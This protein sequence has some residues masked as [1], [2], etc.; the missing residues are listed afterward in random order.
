VD[1]VRKTEIF[2]IGEYRVVD[3]KYPQSAKF[4]SMTYTFYFIFEN[5]SHLP[6]I[7]QNIMKMTFQEVAENFYFA[8]FVENGENSTFLHK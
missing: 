2:K 1:F 6:I 8:I 5:N 3:R 7:L 4:C